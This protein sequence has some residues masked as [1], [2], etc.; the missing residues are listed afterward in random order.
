MSNN[1][2][3]RTVTVAFTTQQATFTPR[4]KLQGDGFIRMK[5]RTISG[6]RIGDTFYTLGQNQEIP[7]QGDSLG[8]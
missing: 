2:N 3:N 1:N 6:Y 8:W 7:Y 5:G 4:G